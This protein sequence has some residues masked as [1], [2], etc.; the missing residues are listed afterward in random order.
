MSA[1]Q[2]HRRAVTIDGAN[3]IRDKAAA[4]EAY[5]RQA[6]DLTLE[7]KVRVIRTRAERKCGELLAEEPKAPAGRPAK[8]P[9]T[10][11]RDSAP[12]TLADMGITYDQ[13]ALWQKLAKVPEDEFEEALA[14]PVGLASASTIVAA[15]EERVNPAPKPP[16]V[17]PRA[18]WLWGRLL[19]F[20]RQGLLDA[21]PAELFQSMPSHMKA[22]VREEAPRVIAWLRR[23]PT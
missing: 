13:S 12:K 1:G 11:T 18:L 4:L 21:D 7:R 8:N 14:N 19:D 3:D 6:R 15:H 9:S 20:E 5:A 22:T 23:L 16:P 10:D 17:D 2:R